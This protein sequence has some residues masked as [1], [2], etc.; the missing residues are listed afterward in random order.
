MKRYSLVLLFGLAGAIPFV[1]GSYQPQS[2]EERA[3]QSKEDE[4]EALATGPVHEAYANPLD[5]NPRLGPTVSKEPPAAIEEIPPEQKPEGNDVQWIPGYWWWDEEEKGY[6]WVSGFWRDI[7]PG[8]RWVPGV[9]L[10]VTDGWQW[11]PGYWTEAETKEVPYVPYPP[12]SIDAGPSTPAPDATSIYVPGCWVYQQTRFVWRPGY[13]MGYRAGWTY[14][15]CHYVRSSGGCVFVA[16]YWD[17]PL[18]RRGLLFAPIRVAR[19]VTLRS[20]TP[21]YVVRNDFLLLSLFVA[22]RRDHYCFGNY[23]SDRYQRSGYTAWLDYRPNKRSADPNF[24][25]YRSAYRDD[26]AWERSLTTYYKARSGADVESPRTWKQQE[27]VVQQLTS[28]KK[29]DDRFTKDVNITNIQTVTA[30]SSLKDVKNTKVTGLATL[31]PRAKVQDVEHTVTLKNVSKEEVSQ[32]QKQVQSHQEIVKQRQQTEHK[33]LQQGGVPT[34]PTQDQQKPLRLELPKETERER[35]KTQVQPPPRPPMPKVEDKVAP[36]QEQPMIPKPQQK[37]P[38]QP[39]PDNK[40]MKP[41]NKPETKPM[42]PETK[43]E[44][45]KE[46]PDNKPDNKPMK[47][48]DRP[49]EA[50]QPKQVQPETPKVVPQPKPVEPMKPKQVQP[51][52]PK[53]VPQPKPAQPMQPQ[54]PKVVPQP[55][56]AQPMQPKQVQP[57]TPK[58]VPQPRPAQ[59]VKPPPVQIQPK[60]VQ[61]QRP[62]VV[63]QQ[64]PTIQ[65]QQPRPAPQSR[66]AR[67]NKPR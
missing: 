27:Q 46:K 57:Q 59:P 17:Y 5:Y 30:L 32:R 48:T 10:A 47:P 33:L 55:K 67:P 26:P 29:R 3:E 38:D 44:K 15:P 66:P 23:G 1:Q 9:W 31:A 43:P 21:S 58:V 40:P 25:Y 12:D 4:F 49:T 51:E 42:K 22:P 2:Q 60:Q 18:H 14:I 37:Q 7:P 62:V 41:E 6:F 28:N 64:R 56:P 34:K 54:T 63:P 36:K 20:Y 39:K 53:V 16:G 24:S 35:P 13:W 19:G 45:P 8:K 11:A 65:P 50:V 61:P 52:T